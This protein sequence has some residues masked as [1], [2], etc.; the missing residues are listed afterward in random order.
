MDDLKT[1]NT[2]ATQEG[3]IQID[4]KDTQKEDD[5]HEKFLR[6]A[7]E[8]ENLRR[9]LAKEKEDSIRFALQS[10]AKDILR[11]AD[12]LMLALQ[13]ADKTSSDIAAFISGIEMTDKELHSIFE[14]HGIKKIESLTKKFDAHCHQAIS[15]E[16]ES[17]SPSQTITKV[18][19]EGYFLHDRL[20]RP[21]LVVVRK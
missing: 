18:F 19:Q 21:A 17:D 2:E 5:Y 11:V 3:E 20:L 1:E 7:A 14:K 16:Q 13:S 6:I 4:N 9:R 15:E 12:H 8:M 10:F